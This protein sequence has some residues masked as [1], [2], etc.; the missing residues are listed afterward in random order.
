VNATS[1]DRIRRCYELMT[2]QLP[3]ILRDLYDRF[4]AARPDLRPLFAAD[5][6]AQ[7]KHFAAALALIVRNLH[8][9]DTLEPPLRELGAAHAR[10]GVRPEHY[11]AIADATVAA[12]ARALAD[13]WTPDLA[14][15][16]HA[17]LATVS[18]HMCAGAQP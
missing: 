17:L 9:L 18:R 16:W 11:R 6:D 8:M 13:A 7:R 1:V 15:D 12:I 3:A 5:L 10:A 2:P 14:A 4:F